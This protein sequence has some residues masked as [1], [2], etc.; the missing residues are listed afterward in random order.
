MFAYPD[1]LCGRFPQGVQ[2]FLMAPLCGEVLSMIPGLPASRGS[3]PAWQNL[4][5]LNVCWPCCVLQPALVPGARM[6]EMESP[7]FHSP[8]GS[9]EG[10]VGKFACV[11]PGG[12]SDRGEP[13]TSS[14]CALTVG[15][16]SR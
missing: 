13:V 12:G 10:P 8:E 3:I 15:P 4:V 16:R 14:M 1:F 7:L 2:G 11:R 6:D 9:E 5:D